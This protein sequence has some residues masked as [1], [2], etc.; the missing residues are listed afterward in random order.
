MGIAVGG[1]GA[2]YSINSSGRRTT[3]FGIPGTGVSYS[4]TSSSKSK[5]RPPVQSVDIS[6][7]SPE[8][9]EKAYRRGKAK[10]LWVVIPF[11]WTG[12]HYFMMRRPGMGFL[13]L[14]TAGLGGIGWL[15]DIVR[16]ATA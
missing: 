8:E 4:H 16:I 10:M 5:K 11:G 9:R 15:V 14:F 13:Y 12:A 3:T 7:L 6:D 2:R 1:K